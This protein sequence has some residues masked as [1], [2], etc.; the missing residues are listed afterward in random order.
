MVKI[1]F[2]NRVAYTFIVIGL[3]VAIAIGVTAYGGNAPATMGHSS[4]ELAP[5]S[6]C[7]AGQYLRLNTLPNSWTCATINTGV[8]QCAG[9]NQS[10]KSINPV[11][12]AVTC[13]LDDF[14]TGGSVSSQW[15]TTGSNIYYN[16]GNVG[17]GTTNPGYRLEVSSSGP[18]AI[19]ASNSGTGS[20]TATIRGISGSSQSSFGVQGISANGF[21]VVGT[22]SSTSGV[23]VYG[24]GNNGALAGKFNGDVEILGSIVNYDGD[25]VIQ[26]G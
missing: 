20:A 12:G 18:T 21:G 8:Y 24:F 6:G 16:S 14:G 13:E 1:N 9:A 11:T 17:I 15:T 4:D 25:V 26:L 7:A 5:P 22:S 2:S 10:L 3:I 23:G 19:S